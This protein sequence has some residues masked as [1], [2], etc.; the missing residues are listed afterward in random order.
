M[1]G[2]LALVLGAGGLV[3]ARTWLEGRRARLPRKRA[4]RLPR[5]QYPIVLAHGLMG[6]DE[7]KLGSNAYQ[8]FRGVPA[9]L[10]ELGAEVHVIRVSPV[11]SLEARGAQLARALRALPVE[12]VNIIAHSMGG[13]DARYAISQLG[14]HDRV[15]SLTTIGTPHRGTPIANVGST[16]FGKLGLRSVCD[17][18]GVDV[19][20]FHDLTT[21]HMDSFNRAV[22]DHPG[23][24]YASYLA[25]ARGELASMN[26][27]LVAPYLYLQEIVGPNDGLVPI[28]S[29]S[30]GDVLG[31]VEAD[32]W[33]Q[34]GLS[35]RFDAPAFYGEILRE[36][37]GRGF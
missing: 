33:A 30:W 23:V 10:R 34:I 14:L 16:L 4:P 37:R 25:E 17:F 20:A 29:Q 5:P 22:F 11:A 28:A 1:L 24:A 18:V 31:R 19:G 21:G 9:R 27:L 12:R 15:L 2:L 35:R 7:I 32:H 6:F 3:L 8:Y 13:L 26:P 36:L